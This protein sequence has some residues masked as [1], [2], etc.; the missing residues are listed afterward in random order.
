MK[1]SGTAWHTSHICA[2]LPDA[3]LMPTICGSVARR[4][5]VAT[6]LTETNG[7]GL[8]PRP[9]TSGRP[10]GSAL[11]RRTRAQVSMNVLDFRTTPLWRVWETVRAEAAEDARTGLAHS[12]GGGA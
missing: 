10:E 12:R 4:T 2:M 7:I 6:S 11:S 9:S 5:T 1:F 8:S 3:S